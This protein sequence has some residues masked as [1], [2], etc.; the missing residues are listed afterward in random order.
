MKSKEASKQATH[1]RVSS[2]PAFDEVYQRVVSWENECLSSCESGSQREEG[3]E[4]VCRKMAKKHETAMWRR[5]VKLQLSLMM[6]V[7]EGVKYSEELL[8]ISFLS[9]KATIRIPC[10]H[11]TVQSRSQCI[12][13]TLGLNSNSTDLTLSNILNLLI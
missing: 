9:Y 3:T 7:R 4:V 8:R 6:K 1:Q 13:T 5:F 10:S 12:I 11:E 2:L